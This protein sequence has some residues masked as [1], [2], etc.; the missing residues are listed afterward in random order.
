MRDVIEIG[1]RAVQCKPLIAIRCMR[2]LIP[3][4]EEYEGGCGVSSSL[5]VSGWRY[6]RETDSG[7][8]IQ[9]A[10]SERVCLLTLP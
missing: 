5:L 1:Y 6:V 8:L 2:I 4:T 3:Q 9:R 10:E 7:K